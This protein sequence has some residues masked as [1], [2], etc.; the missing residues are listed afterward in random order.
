MCSVLTQRLYCIRSCLTSYSWSALK[1]WSSSYPIYFYLGNIL[2]GQCRMEI[3]ETLDWCLHHKITS[4]PMNAES[5]W[6]SFQLRRIELKWRNGNEYFL[7]RNPNKVVI[8][9]T[10]WSFPLFGSR[11][12]CLWQFFLNYSKICSVQHSALTGGDRK[13]LLRNLLRKF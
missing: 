12:E 2:R 4:T 1:L 10:F 5:C 3:S 11:K 9:Q 8:L 13:I 7:L 6:R